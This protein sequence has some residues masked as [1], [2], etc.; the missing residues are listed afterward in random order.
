[1]T[2]VITGFLRKHSRDVGLCSL[3]LGLMEKL[4]DSDFVCPCQPSLNIFLSVGYAIE[5]FLTC[6]I[7]TWFYL[8]VSSMTETGGEEEESK[9]KATC[10]T[11]TAL[12][13][14]DRR[15]EKKSKHDKVFN[16]LIISLIW[17]FF[18]FMDGQYVACACS[19]WGG[20]YTET[21][22]LKWCKP[23]GNDTEVFERQQE[24]LYYITIFQVTDDLLGSSRRDVKSRRLVSSDSV[25]RWFGVLLCDNTSRGGV[26][27]STS[28][29]YEDGAVTKH[30]ILLAIQSLQSDV[31]P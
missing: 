4:M 19:C 13:L 2:K 11:D 8:D 10:S 31:S 7:Y 22:A 12:K 5:P 16:S 29:R 24:T 25:I 21:G 20:E 27:N 30:R 28:R 23:K 15:G 6:F 3:F 14:E 9:R 26:M 18:F 1:M 17:L